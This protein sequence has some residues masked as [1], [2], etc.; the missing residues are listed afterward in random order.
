MKEAENGGNIVIV[1][2]DFSYDEVKEVSEE[3]SLLDSILEDD[4]DETKYYSE[5]CTIIP[6][7]YSK[8]K[9]MKKFSCDLCAF[10]ATKR[11]GVERHK[12]YIHNEKY[13]CDECGYKAY[14]TTHLKEHKLVKHEG[15]TFSCDLCSFVARQTSYLKKHKV[16]KH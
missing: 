10:R 9:K 8:G 4:T 13:K 16:T 11:I 5:N 1:G 6:K 15:V 12:E 3:K 2:S 7:K 14:N